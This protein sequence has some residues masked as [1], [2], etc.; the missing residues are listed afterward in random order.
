[1]LQLRGMPRFAGAKLHQFPQ[2]S[3]FFQR[4]F[5]FIYFSLFYW[6]GFISQPTL[7]LVV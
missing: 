2:M 1:M 6:R 5:S 7:F 4:Y 3:K